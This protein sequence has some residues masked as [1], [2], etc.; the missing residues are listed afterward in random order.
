MNTKAMRNLT[1]GLF[2][3]TAASDF[4]KAVSRQ[5]LILYK[6]GYTAKTRK[7]SVILHRLINEIKSSHR[8]NG[9]SIK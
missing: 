6:R 1:Y 9:G 2:I 7:I 5:E 3:L 4:E 8:K